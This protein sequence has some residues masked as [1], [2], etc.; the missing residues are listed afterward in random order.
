M[1]IL[2][3]PSPM[4]HFPQ[5]MSQE[6]ANDRANK[7]YLVLFEFYP[8]EDDE[9]D[10]EETMTWRYCRGTQTAYNF[11]RE[12]IIEHETIG[13]PV[14]FN[15][16]FIIVESVKRTIASP[17]SIYDFVKEMVAKDKVIED[18][19]FNIDDYSNAEYD[20]P[21]DVDPT[22]SY[23]QGDNP[24]QYTEAEQTIDGGEV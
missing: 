24:E 19:G 6:E 16:S 8:P 9:S 7:L 2:E 15:N 4:S 21:E 11:I 23:G 5:S 12:T 3:N 18:T 13:T 20:D 1:Q 10:E 22:I 14:N 17:L